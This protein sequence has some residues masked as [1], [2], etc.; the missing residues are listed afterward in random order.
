MQ[1]E[2]Y[3]ILGTL[4]FEHT[5]LYT[6]ARDAAIDLY[7]QDGANNLE[8]NPQRYEYTPVSTE[9]YDHAQVK[10]MLLEYRTRCMLHNPTLWRNSTANYATS[11]LLAQVVTSE[12][13][14][15]PVVKDP[16]TTVKDPQITANSL[17]LERTAT[18]P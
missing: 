1:N 12:Y 18:L 7:F 2:T 16:E 10:Q 8:K 6:S 14:M 9:D 13:L 3:N 17:P 5:G 4:I 11:M 15:Q